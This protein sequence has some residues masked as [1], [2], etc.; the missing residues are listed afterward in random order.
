MS[1]LLGS[2]WP[3]KHLCR[4]F[5]IHPPTC[6]LP[7]GYIYREV[8]DIVSTCDQVDADMG[9]AWYIRMETDMGEC[10]GV[11]HAMRR[12]S[13]V[14]FGFAFAICVLCV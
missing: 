3:S 4:S 9:M 14:F 11:A 5:H 1:H 10:E 13:G 8:S 12:V 2:E 7:A 6:P